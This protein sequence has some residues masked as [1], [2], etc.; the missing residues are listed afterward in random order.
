M[1]NTKNFGRALVAGVTATVLAFAAACGS[2][3]AQ[4]NSA[5]ETVT[6]G[7]LTVATGEPAYTPWVLNNKP[8]SGEGYEAA[9]IYAVAKELG[10]KDSD[11]KWTRSTFDSAIAPG[12]KDWDMNIQ[13]FS[14]TE[15]RKKAVDFSPSYYNTTQAMVV[16]SDNKFANA[17]SLADLKDAVIG[18][19][20]GTTSYEQAKAKIKDDIKLYNNNDDA[21]AALS[22]GQIDVLVVDT[23]TAVNMVESGQAG[24]AGKVLGQ[25]ADSEDKEGMG[26]LLPK[27]SKLTAKVTKA[28]NTMQEN[29]TLKQLQ[30]KW[31]SAYTTLT[32]LK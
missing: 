31:L 1:L 7:K 15:D 16:Q 17:T 12:A 4:N 29:G 23:P 20:T 32:V 24:K 21:V 28:I 27:G 5:S 6:D 9:V 3:G 2:T 10:Y 22:S 11:V 25:I 14:I 26:I 8:E 19:M 18:S 13:Q 30:D